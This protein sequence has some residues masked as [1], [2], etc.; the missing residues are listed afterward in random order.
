MKIDKLIFVLEK[1]KKDEGNLDI[2][3]FDFVFR[4]YFNII[5]KEIKVIEDSKEKKT[6]CLNHV[7]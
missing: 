6:L 2:Q 7:G 3:I 4:A 5:A 1:I